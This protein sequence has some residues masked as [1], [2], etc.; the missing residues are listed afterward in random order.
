MVCVTGSMKRS[1]VR[2]YVCPSVRSSA[3]PAIDSSNGRRGSGLLL[4]APQVRDIDRQQAPALSSNCARRSMAPEHGAQQ[5]MRAA[6]RSQ[7]TYEAGH[8]LVT[9]SMFFSTFDHGLRGSASPVLTAT[10]FVNG[11]WQFSTPHRIQAP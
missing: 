3:C 9:C 6:S 1:S 7:P 11:R 4:S 5:Q 2:L 10:G 8:R